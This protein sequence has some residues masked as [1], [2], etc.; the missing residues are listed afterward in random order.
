MKNRWY[1]IVAAVALAATAL[2]VPSGSAAQS[3]PARENQ[4]QDWT[5][6]DLER[7]QR[8]VAEAMRYSQDEL[9]RQLAQLRM[10]QS[11]IARQ[12]RASVEQAQAELRR[13][14]MDSQV[15]RQAALYAAQEATTHV[16]QALEQALAQAQERSYTVLF[17]GDGSGWLGVTVNEVT[18]DRVKELKLP[19]ERGVY[20]AEVS[21]DS[22][23]AKAGFKAGD[24][25]TEFNGTRIEG[26]EQ[27]SRLVRET[28]AGRT[29]QLTVW[30][31]GRA[32]T[33]SAE[34]SNR[35]ARV[36]TF[37]APNLVMPRIEGLFATT[38]P[39][40]GVSTQ[41]V[42]GQLGKY[43]SVPDD[44]GVL[45]TEV[46][47]GSP[48]EK[49]GLKAGDVIVKV[50]GDRVR[51]SAEL[52]QKLAE[53]REQKSIAIGVIRKGAETTINVE[54]EQPKPPVRRSMARRVA[55]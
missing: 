13:Q 34:L 12:V 25:I 36:Q 38:R 3:N 32:Q 39:V 42:D 17:D 14:M 11:Q 46:N 43:F 19:A 35:T 22:P 50:A 4:D 29:V 27:F 5:R 26:T 6:A 1:A 21:S 55:I 18:A 20:V 33:L 30:R 7:I 51:N 2:V 41:D 54:P 24:V 8:Q 15:H 48:A 9:R 47:S 52:R 23:A 31:D 37:A 40:L 53:K 44:E 45:I 28:P 10:N 16:H 49:A